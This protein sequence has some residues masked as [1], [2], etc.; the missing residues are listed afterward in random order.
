MSTLT[1]PPLRG[2]GDCETSG[3]ECPECGRDW[4]NPLPGRPGEYEC[5]FPGCRWQG[6]LPEREW[7]VELA[8]GSG[9]EAVHA[10]VT[11]LA[12][13]RKR[14]CRLA[15]RIAEERHGL[16]RESRA[17]RVLAV[18]PVSDEENLL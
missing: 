15:R 1:L 3:L 16:V 7:S 10:E 8:V 4:L 9:E 11:V 6:E 18:D 17:V 5:S 12:P 2:V 14:A 13:E